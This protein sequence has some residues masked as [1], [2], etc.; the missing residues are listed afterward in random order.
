MVWGVALTEQAE[1]DL[2]QAV[3]FL[4]A[5]NPAAAER[6]GLGLVDTIFS[7]DHLPYRGPAVLARPGYRRI[8]HRPW[9]LIFYRV[10]ETEHRIEIVRIWDG[11]QNPNRLTL[12][13]P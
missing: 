2:E 3:E 7:L 12:D 4:A 1:R 13:P 11:R 9:H 8:L 5:Q 10:N 6:L